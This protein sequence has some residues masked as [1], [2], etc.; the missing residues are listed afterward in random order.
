MRARGS[1]VLGDGM[2]GAFIH[3]M[4]HIGK[5]KLLGE[6]TKLQGKKAFIEVYERTECVHR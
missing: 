3:E 5:D 6:I 1:L 2:D 4:V